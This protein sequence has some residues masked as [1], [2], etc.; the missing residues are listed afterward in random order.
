VTVPND[1]TVPVA[2]VSG[3]TLIVAGTV[4]A[5]VAAYFVTWLV[6]HQIGLARYEIF[7]VA[8]SAIY[9]VVGT[10][11]GI[12]Q[13][14]SRAT[15]RIQPSHRSRTSTARNFGLV[16]GVATFALVIASATLWQSSV[17]PSEGWS[18]VWPL[19]VATGSYVFVAVLCGTLYGLSEWRAI[20][21]LLVVDALLRLAAVSIV[22]FFTTDVVILGWAVAIPFPLALVVLWPFLR[23]RVVGKTQLDVGY[24]R[25]T[26]NVARTVLAA[27]S[28]SVM[29]SG[30]PLLLG[31]S[32]RGEP[33]SIVGLYILTITLTRAPLIVV[34]ISL[35][36]YFVVTFRDGGE[37]FWRRFLRFQALIF[38]IGVVLAVVG[39]FAG[40]WVFRL[41]FP[42]ALAPSGWFIM[43]LVF[44]SAL[45]GSLCV[46]APAVL[47]RGRHFVYSAGWCF[48]ALATVVAL[49]L[50]LDFTL[51]TVLALVCGPVIGLG[52][53]GGYLATVWMRERRR[54]PHTQLD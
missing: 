4:V 6:P 47:A 15:E 29:V 3:F 54:S 40:P 43:V 7:A 9:L 32:S 36:S 10:L 8:W 50:P 26:W 12:Q 37:N 52:V 35:Q 44:S 42:G 1:V 16:A 38:G 13:E 27:A 11:G 33:R 51:R 24:R 45:V 28:T 17:F 23:G 14:V 31:I 2:R 34:A 22:L 5:G 41:L 53:Q 30:F 20:A 49:V 19:A 39:L 48:A 25:L 18:L 21:S 46:S